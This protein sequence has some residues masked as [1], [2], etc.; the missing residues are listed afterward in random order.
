MGVAQRTPQEGC[1]VHFVRGHDRVG[2]QE[3]KD[4]HTTVG[5]DRPYPE[6]LPTVHMSCQ[7]HSDRQKMNAGQ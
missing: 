2:S 7:L 1:S 4:D 6:S 3:G 5:P